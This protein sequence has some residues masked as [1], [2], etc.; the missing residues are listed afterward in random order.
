[1]AVLSIV[2]VNSMVVVVV[3]GAVLVG[4][5]MAV[6]SIVPVNSMVVVVVPGAVL[7]GCPWTP[8][9]DSRIAIA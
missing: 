5:V 3:P 4:C 7:V 2:P 9:M 8:W 6:L 1:M